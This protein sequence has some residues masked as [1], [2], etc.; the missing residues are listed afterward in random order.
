[1]G[2]WSFRR[3][4]RAG[5]SD[6]ATP[7]ASVL[8]SP[9]P[10]ER[11][12]SR[13]RPPTAPRRRP[14]VVLAVAV[15]FAVTLA[16]AITTDLH[17]DLARPRPSRLYLDRRG[18]FLAELPGD[19]DVLGAWPL[20]AVLPDRIV[21]A[22]LE[23]EDRRFFDHPGVSLR[24][25]ARAAW[26]DLRAREI[27]SG[28]ST[29]AMQTARLQSPGRR[30]IL[31]KAKEAIEALLLVRRHG[32]DA[33]LR[34]YLTL[35]P[36]GHR[37][38]GV[39]RASRLYFAKPV[40]DLSWAQAAFIAALPQA[41]GRMDPYDPDGLARAT[42]RAHRI[43][44]TLRARGVIDDDALAQALHADLGLAARPRRDP[45]ALHAVLAL[46]AA[47]ASARA[48][49]VVTTTLDLELQRIAARAVADG[50]AAL[51]DLDASN[52]AALVVDPEDGSVLAQ[53]GSADY[54][55]A[56]A[57]GAIDFTRVPRSPGSALKPFVYALALASGRATAATELEDTPLDV[58]SEG[59]AFLPENA[60]HAWFGPMLLRPALANSR[61][62]PALRLAAEV[63]PDRI[64][65]LLAKAGLAAAEKAPQGLGI[66]IGTLPASLEE[67]AQAYLLLARGGT[68][69]P[70]RR[71][72]DAPAGAPRRL[73]PEA[74]AR[75]VAD[76]LSDPEARRPTFPP[77][78]PLDYPYAVAVK[79]GTSQGFRDAWAIAVSDRL[80][81]AVWVGNHD[82]RRMNAVTGQAGAAPI[83]HAILD[84]TMPLR[85]PHRLV[86]MAPA[87]T[88]G[89]VVRTV[90]ALSGRLAGKDCP[91]AR[92]EVF[93]PGTEPTDACPW[94]R[95]VAVDARNGLRAT[96]SCPP[97]FVVS[98]RLLDL[99]ERYA[100]WARAQRLP[101]AP[102]QES[103]LCPRWAV[104]P[105]V[106]VL[107]P[108]AGARYLLDPDAPRES[109]TIRLAARVV[110]ADE[111]VV[112]L[113]DGVPVA[114]V[115]WPHEFRWTA[116]PGA[117]VVSAALARRAVTSRG[118][119]I[120]VG[121]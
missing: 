76:I 63:G 34:Q 111:P 61:N 108:R 56:E 31:R 87:P 50:V 102:L 71:L 80:V 75:L 6:T 45:A 99:P 84:A 88:P 86:A 69:I 83:A 113:V 70:L 16:L 115:P 110:P 95:P 68:A 17:G 52:G 32:H 46:E 13:S 4:W 2:W 15:A 22:T 42:R 44:R 25:L 20:P 35:A 73:L 64:Q 12:P 58:V 28:G 100:G 103:P 11:V 55:D 101:V 72:A 104:A 47:G 93:L 29:V 107:E 10:G 14:R 106:A 43:L 114:T 81:V 30:T 8:P 38:R 121:D 40:E 7:A 26:Q 91:H 62:I 74:A 57:R 53:V 85:A 94:H 77:G 105:A 9:P 1:M 19:G 65:A 109:A 96:A 116:T 5:A 79:T 54:F 51:R 92:A 66:A 78:G 118:V 33:V 59:G 60:N 37:V 24:S 48:A 98:R 97:R 67:L 21:R 120:T 90:C 41:P 39:A 36:Y 3:W 117:H 112:F 89:A 23:T 27:V 49:A 82:R 119:P 18:E